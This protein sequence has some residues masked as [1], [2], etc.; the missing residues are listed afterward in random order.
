MDEIALEVVAAEIYEKYRMVASG[1]TA[2]G[3]GCFYADGKATL[4]AVQVP[5]ELLERLAKAIGQKV[6][7]RTSSD[8]Y[9]HLTR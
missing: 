3:N 1:D 2:G 5:V 9:P 4:N 8:R 7:G 6:Y